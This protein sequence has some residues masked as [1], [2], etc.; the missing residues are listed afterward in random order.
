MGSKGDQDKPDSRY[1][2][3]RRGPLSPAVTLRSH[4]LSDTPTP[5][6]APRPRHKRPILRGDIN[7]VMAG[8]LPLFSSPQFEY[9]H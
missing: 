4:F 5:A 3:L 7:L 8:L 2:S 6:P 1:P 9:T